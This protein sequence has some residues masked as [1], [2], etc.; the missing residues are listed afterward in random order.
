[1]KILNPLSMLL[2][3]S[4]SVVLCLIIYFSDIAES[5]QTVEKIAATVA[6]P[7]Y[8]HFLIN[9]ILSTTK[10]LTY[11]LR[12]QIQ[13]ELIGVGALAKRGKAIEVSSPLISTILLKNVVSTRKY[14]FTTIPVTDGLLDVP[15]LIQ[16]VIT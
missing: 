12:D 15:A 4:Q 2:L 6:E 11:N 16:C 7:K 14:Y 3:S 13:L 8:S 9:H 10:V 1:M 5:W